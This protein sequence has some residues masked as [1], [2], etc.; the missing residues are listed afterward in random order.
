VFFRDRFAAAVRL[1]HELLG[2]AGPGHAYR[3]VFSE[4]DG[5][6]G[7]VVDRY[8]DWLAVQFTALG[9]ARRRE[10]FAELLVELLGP[11]GIYL[12]TERGIGKLEGLELQ[13]GPLW[14]EPPPADLTVEE[15]GLRLPVNL[16]EGQKTGFYLD[17]RDN[18]LAAARYAPGKRVLDAFCYS[19]GFGLHA[20]RAGAAEVE[21][22]DVSEP[23]LALARQNA[24]LNGLA[25][26][27]FTKAD[28]FAHLAALV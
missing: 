19:G 5:L 13:D 12:R 9:L 28:V 23:A 6:S 4:G 3:V 25:G 2:L 14:G 22:I 26:V 15:H 27:T 16:A 17:Q 7:C 20:A 8:G 18:R 10:L 1:R 11:R 21:G 24:E